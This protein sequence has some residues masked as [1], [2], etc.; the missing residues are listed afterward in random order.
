M[1]SISATHSK[2]LLDDDSVLCLV[3][4]ILVQAFL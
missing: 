1:L 3:S 4:L 2:T